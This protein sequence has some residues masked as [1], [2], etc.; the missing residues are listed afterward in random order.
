MARSPITR[1]VE[2][3]PALM[4]VPE[5]EE[6]SWSASRIRFMLH[7]SADAYIDLFYPSPGHLVAVVLGER[8]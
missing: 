7:P 8:L 2:K 4:P 3:E 5:D 1:V 6:V